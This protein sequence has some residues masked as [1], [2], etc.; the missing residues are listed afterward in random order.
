M[1]TI[2]WTGLTRFSG[3]ISDT[4][5]SL[6]IIITSDKIDP[7]KT[8]YLLWNIENPLFKPKNQIN[9]YLYPT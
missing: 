6:T 5:H 1:E 2:W 7:S 4:M 8:G 9:T 3:N